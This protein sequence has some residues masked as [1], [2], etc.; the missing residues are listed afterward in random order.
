[1]DAMLGI[2]ADKDSEASVAGIAKIDDSLGEAEKPPA[3][4]ESMALCPVESTAG[5]CM[6][7]RGID[8]DRESK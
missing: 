8:G 1:M 6:T 2:G 7:E 5:L 4:E 3:Y